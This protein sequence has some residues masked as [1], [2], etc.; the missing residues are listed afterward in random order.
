VGSLT[1]H[2]PIGL[3]GLLRDSF[4]YF[5]FFGR[6]VTDSTIT[7][8]ITGLLCQ[9]KIMMSGAVGG[10]VDRGNRST[11]RKPAHGPHITLPMLE[12]GPPM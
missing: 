11:G 8:A 10:M 4:T 2:N 9:I 6:S 1:S 7:E 5:S 3:Q 12:P